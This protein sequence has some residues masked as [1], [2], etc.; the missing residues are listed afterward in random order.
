MGCVIEILTNDQ[1]Q[2]NLK[3]LQIDWKEHLKI[4]TSPVNATMPHISTVSWSSFS[5][6]VVVCVSLFPV[7]MCVSHP[8]PNIT[9]LSPPSLLCCRLSLSLSYCGWEMWHPDAQWDSLVFLSCGLWC[10]AKII[11]INVNIV[12]SGGMLKVFGFL[13]LKNKK[14]TPKNIELICCEVCVHHLWSHC[15]S[16]GKYLTLKWLKFKVIKLYLAKNKL[17]P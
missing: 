2:T 3:R 13:L 6:V 17:T 4:L 14:K 11:N 16:V 15:W 12:R 10:C 8:D 1:C 5:W 7:F 9:G